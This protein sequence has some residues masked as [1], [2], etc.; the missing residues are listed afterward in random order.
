[1]PDGD[2]LGDLCDPCLSAPLNDADIDGYCA[3]Q[4]ICPSVHDPLQV[5]SDGDGVGDACDYV[6][7]DPLVLPPGNLIPLVTQY[8]AGGS[9][10][11][12]WPTSPGADSYSVTRGSVSERSASTRPRRTDRMRTR[13]PAPTSRAPR[14]LTRVIRKPGGVS[15]TPPPGVRSGRKTQSM[16]SSV[17]GSRRGNSVALPP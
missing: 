15:M 12:V 7:Y 17:S 4:G 16:G 14:R 11:L 5:D 9:A 13:M 8:A 6:T 1:M 3:D 10:L 2:G